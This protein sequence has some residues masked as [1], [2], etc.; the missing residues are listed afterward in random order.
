MDQLNA[1][2]L[3]YAALMVE[4]AKACKEAAN[5]NADRS[6]ESAWRNLFDRMMTTH[7]T[8]HNLAQELA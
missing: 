6:W 2:A 4:Y 1:L 3:S 5:P 7:N 8:M